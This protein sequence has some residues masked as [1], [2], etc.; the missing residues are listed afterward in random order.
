[1]EIAKKKWM[2]RSHAPTHEVSV[3]VARL[4][5]LVAAPT[6]LAA[7]VFAMQV[8]RQLEELKQM[9]CSEEQQEAMLAKQFY[10]GMKLASSTAW[11]TKTKKSALN[12]E[13]HSA[14]DYT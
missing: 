1:M 7:N 8:N 14:F 12:T 10:L 3:R 6:D 4:P 2:E 5:M 11:L 13:I 9:F